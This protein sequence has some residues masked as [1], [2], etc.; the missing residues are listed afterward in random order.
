MG[1]GVPAVTRFEGGDLFN[2]GAANSFK[3]RTQATAAF[4]FRSRIS[5]QVD[6]GVAYEIP[7]T[8]EDDS[9]I[10]DRITLDLVWKF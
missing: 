5:E 1:G 10:E 8:P 2:I 4:G 9:V 7:L 6:I 3:S